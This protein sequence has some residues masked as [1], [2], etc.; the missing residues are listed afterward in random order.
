MIEDLFTA[1]PAI[2][3]RDGVKPTNALLIP[4]PDADEN[5]QVG[6]KHMFSLLAEI[7]PRPEIT[8]N[9]MEEITTVEGRH[10]ALDQSMVAILLAYGDPNDC[11]LVTLSFMPPDISMTKH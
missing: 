7:D 1:D 6:L 11:R 2:F 4:H 9:P 8:L 3:Y 5:A 10:Q